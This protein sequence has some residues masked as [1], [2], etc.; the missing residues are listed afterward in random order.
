[1]FVAVRH[2]ETRVVDAIVAA[3]FD[4]ITLAQARVA[5]RI[6]DEGSR[7]TE[8][9]AAAQVTK[10]TAGAMVDQ[11]ERAGYVERIPDPSDA[12]AK[13]VQFAPRGREVLAVARRVEEEIRAEWEQHLGVRRLRELTDSLEKLREITDPWA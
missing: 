4:D 13:L 2:I 8:L 7:L 3:G 11:L 6:G 12:R 10:Q 1:M 5:A 9:A